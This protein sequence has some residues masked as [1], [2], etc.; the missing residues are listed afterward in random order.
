ME[1]VFFNKYQEL[2]TIFYYPN[3]YYLY[4]GGLYNSS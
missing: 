2:M 4:I 3:K 1:K